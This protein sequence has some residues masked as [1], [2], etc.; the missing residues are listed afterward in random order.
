ML[1]RIFNASLIVL[2]SNYNWW[3]GVWIIIECYFNFCNS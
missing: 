1:L 2:V 3:G